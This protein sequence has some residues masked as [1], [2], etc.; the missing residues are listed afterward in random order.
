MHLL[1][2]M[3][4]RGGRNCFRQLHVTPRPEKHHSSFL[5]FTI[6]FTTHTHTHKLLHAHSFVCLW[7]RCCSTFLPCWQFMR[8]SVV[9][10]VWIAVTKSQMEEKKIRSSQHQKLHLHAACCIR[11]T[12]F[13][14]IHCATELQP[15]SAHPL[16]CWEFACTFTLAHI[17]IYEKTTGCSSCC[18]CAEKKNSHHIVS[19]GSTP[20]LFP[21]V[22]C[23]ENGN[24]SKTKTGVSKATCHTS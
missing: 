15:P 17:I 18:F 5:H 21:A 9:M 8:A 6:S 4:F 10:L 11:S 20:F 12:V 23:S 13:S 14:D 22:S 19:T 1:P 3:P 7:S 24:K 2:C 16:E